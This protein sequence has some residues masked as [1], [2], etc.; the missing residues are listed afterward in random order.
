MLLADGC[1]W[2]RFARVGVLLLPS[3]PGEVTRASESERPSL[4]P[5][6]FPTARSTPVSGVSV[7]DATR[8]A[9]SPEWTHILDCQNDVVDQ[10]RSTPPQPVLVRFDAPEI[11][12][13]TI[14]GTATDTLDGGRRL[15]Y[16]CTGGRATYAYLDNRP[17]RTVAPSGFAV[18]AVTACHAAVTTALKRDRRA[19]PIAFETAGMMPTDSVLF[20]RGA[21]TDSSRPGQF[22]PFTY[23]CQWDGT[24]IR[25]ATFT[26]VSR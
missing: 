16:R 8:P 21:G 10:L 4:R 14:R 2:R 6:P 26:L 3:L 15:S 9:L 7:P 20:V 25:G 22:Q 5:A 11:S 13:T 23:Q 18:E 24:D 12:T 19:G 17:R 1:W